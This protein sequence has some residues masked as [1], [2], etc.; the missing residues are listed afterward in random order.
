MAKPAEPTAPPD[1]PPDAGDAASDAAGGDA[2]ADL[3]DPQIDRLADALSSLAGDGE[4]DI[5]LKRISPATIDGQRANTMIPGYRLDPGLDA[6]G[7]AERIFRDHGGGNYHVMFRRNGR[8]IAGRTVPLPL[9]GR[10]KLWVPPP[11]PTDAPPPE[12]GQGDKLE[13]M[14]EKVVLSAIERMAGGTGGDHMA[15]TASILESRVAGLTAEKQS[16]S[17]KLDALRAD[18]VEAKTE[19]AR[20]TGELANEKNLRERAE[21]DTEK[22]E[23]RLERE[24]VESKRDTKDAVK[25]GNRLREALAEAKTS[26]GGGSELQRFLEMKELL[27]PEK[28]FASKLEEVAETSLFE[29]LAKAMERMGR[30]GSADDGS[31]TQKDIVD[32][33]E[34]GID[35]FMRIREE[36]G[37]GRFGAQRGG[38]EG[39]DAQPAKGRVVGGTPGAPADQSDGQARQAAA[40]QQ[41]PAASSA[42]PQPEPEQATG[43]TMLSDG[44]WGHIKQLVAAGHSGYAF[45]EQVLAW[46]EAED[47]RAL[48][49]NPKLVHT[50]MADPLP[51]VLRLIDQWATSEQKEILLGEQGRAFLGGWHKFWQEL[52]AAQNKAAA[53]SKE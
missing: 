21:R 40:A 43:F 48:G 23:A 13:K 46:D 17:D 2:G 1:A 44:M 22:I 35:A 51:K 3:S 28:S 34:K 25:D 41:A 30:V 9:P 15:G 53:E 24:L 36:R 52:H 16:L 27:T 49:V 37:G 4:I 11:E 45:G 32:V 12:N 47:P 10:A 38:R 31:L 50:C 26:G 6:W 39:D 29:Q 19:V 14:T 18:H 8:L 42:P 5:G 20:L 7:I 33:L